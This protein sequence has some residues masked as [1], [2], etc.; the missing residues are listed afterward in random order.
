MKTNTFNLK[1]TAQLLCIAAGLSVSSSVMAGTV[2]YNTG[3]AATA[4]VALGV[5]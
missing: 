5:N 2:I 3:H 1:K 4:T